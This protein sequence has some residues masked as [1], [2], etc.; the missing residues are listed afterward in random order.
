MENI[1]TENDL[2]TRQWKLYRLIKRVYK[3]NPN[4]N[5]T[6]RSI[7]NAMYEDYPPLNPKSTWN[8]QAARRYI[9]DDLSAIRAS[10]IPQ[11]IVLTTSRGSKIARKNEVNQLERERI[12]LLKSLK[13][14]N[15]QLS[16]VKMD[17]QK[18]IVLN[19][20]KEYIDTFLEQLEEVV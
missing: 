17:G 19:Q 3:S 15:S 9:T 4:K 10:K 2:T 18:R 8:N 12:S 1:K 16:K 6:N 11:V 13:T 14:V 7:Y 20:E 5:L